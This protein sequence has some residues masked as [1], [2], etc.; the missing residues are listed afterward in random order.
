MYQ[1]RLAS[2]RSEMQ[3]HSIGAIIIPTTDPHQSEYITD[4]WKCREWLTGF[5]GSAGI[6]IVTQNHAGLWTDSR[7][8]I[9]AENELIPPFVLHKQQTK[10]PEYIDWLFKNL[11]FSDS[12]GFNGH[13]FSAADIENFSKKFQ[14]K[15]IKM[16]D[17]DD[18]FVTIWKDRPQIPF[19]EIFEHNVRFAGKTRIEKIDKLKAQLKEIG[20]TNLLVT[21]LDDIAWLLNIRGNDVKYNPVAASFFLIAQNQQI[22][23]IDNKKIPESLSNALKE[24]NI[25]MLPYKEINNKIKELKEFSRIVVDK[26]ST[27]SALINSIPS[28]CEIVDKANTVAKLKAIKNEIEISN[29]KAAQVRDGIALCNF[30]QWLE[31]NYRTETI[32]EIDAAKKLELFRSVQNNFIGLSFESISAFGAN[33]ALPHYAPNNTTNTV[34]NDS[35]LYLIDSGGQYLDGTTDITRTIALGIPTKEQIENFTLVLKGH[36]KLTTTIFPI[37]TKGYQLDPLAREALWQKGKDY[38]HGTGH[39]IGFFLNVHEG[40]QGFSTEA[41]G[42]AQNAFEPGMLTTNEPGF[43]LENEYG[44]R[45]ENVLLCINDKTINTDNFLAFETISYCPIDLKLI[46]K[47]MLTEVEINW[48]NEYHKKTCDILSPFASSETAKWLAEKTKLI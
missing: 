31:Q 7:Y 25:I 13:L 24:D 21:K 9:Q 36:I 2:L 5:K 29:Y 10:A 47:E 44:I 17:T 41:N 14:M 15:Q 37:G 32:T 34:I 35:N 33:A 30:L 48:I 38:A 8:F 42:P 11:S 12:I 27:N 3:K 18:L 6:A 16:I 1:E 22:L 28:A 23:F 26:K 46:N 45:I 39:G 4:Y 20:A 40:P 43:Y 19:F